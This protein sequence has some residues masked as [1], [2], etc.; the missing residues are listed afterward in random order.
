MTAFQIQ[1]WESLGF[2]WDSLR[3]A[4]EDRLNELVDIPKIHGH[5]NV[6][7]KC[8]GNAKLASW[9]TTQRKQYML[10]VK[11]KPSHMTLPR[12]Q[13]LESLRFDWKP[14]SGWDKGTPKKSSV[15][16][17]ATC[18]CES[19]VGAPEHGQTTAQTQKDCSGRNIPSSNQVDVA[20]VPEESD[21]S[22]EGHLGYI[23]GRTEEI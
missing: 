12:I 18:V 13:A 17:N 16:D 4:F 3:V 2:E 14:S 8:S 21:W 1:K 5:C 19:V 10:H 11:G 23:P 20:F 9:V 15:D 7:K 22:D 6:P